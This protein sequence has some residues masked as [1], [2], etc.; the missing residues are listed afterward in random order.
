MKY[1][2]QWPDYFTQHQFVVTFFEF[3]S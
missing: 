3:V 2:S 1:Y